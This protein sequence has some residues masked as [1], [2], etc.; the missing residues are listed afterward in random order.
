[1]THKSTRR[2]ARREL[3]E[4]QRAVPRSTKGEL[5][6]RRDDDVGHEVAVALEGAARVA[7]GLAVAAGVRQR[8]D[9]AGLVAARGDDHPGVLGRRREG[10]DP[11]AVALED[12]A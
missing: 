5:A 10:R 3:P 2:L 7:V 9:E 1:M 11:V 12:A 8:P 4:P 6:V